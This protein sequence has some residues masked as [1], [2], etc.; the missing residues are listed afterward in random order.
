MGN[1][2]IALLNTAMI[3][4]GTATAAAGQTPPRYQFDVRA[5]DLKFALRAVTREAGLQLFADADDLRNR[6]S[7]ELHAD[8][9]VQDA[10]QRLLAGTGL[11]AE[12]NGKSVF[13]RG[14]S[15]PR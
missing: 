9:T 8:T 15:E 5:Q 4:F 3:A 7:P 1:K 6:R 10:L 12:I 2:R 11:H 14:R 13:I